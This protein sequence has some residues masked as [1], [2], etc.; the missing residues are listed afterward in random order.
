M[1]RTELAMKV[2]K[3]W[4]VSFEKVLR[5]VDTAVDSELGSSVDEIPNELAKDIEN[6]FD[7]EY[8]Q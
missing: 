4:N 5:G 1:L 8:E 3:K 7:C 6:G 2:S